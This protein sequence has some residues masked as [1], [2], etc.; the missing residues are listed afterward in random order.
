MRI[1]TLLVAAASVLFSAACGPH[2][3][4]ADIDGFERFDGELPEPTTFGDEPEM[5]TANLVTGRPGYFEFQVEEVAEVTHIFIQADDAVF[6]AA[7][8]DLEEVSLCD[9]LDEANSGDLTSE[10]LGLTSDCTAACEEA[11]SCFQECG[12]LPTDLGIIGSPA[13]LCTASCSQANGSIE[14]GEFADTFGDLYSCTPQSCNT[15]SQWFGI[16]VEVNY[17]EIK[18]EGLLTQPVAA[19]TR[20]SLTSADMSAPGPIRSGVRGVITQYD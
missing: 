7:V 13:A 10:L 2:Q 5:R 12:D 17:P 16:V 6:V 11:C 3:W 20:E 15:P 19:P 4:V 1:H 14:A 8:D 18:S 9:W